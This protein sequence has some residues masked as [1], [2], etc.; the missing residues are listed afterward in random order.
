MPSN[1]SRQALRR[2]RIAGIAL[3]A[4]ILLAIAHATF[5]ALPA[6]PAGAAAWIAGGLLLGRLPGSQKLQLAVLTGVGAAT[7]AWALA[8]GADPRLL[9]LVD[10]NAMLLTMIASV[11]FL[12]LVAA[13]ERA[14]TPAPI[15][16][17]AFARTLA[18]VA[19]FGSFINVSAPL[20]IADHLHARGSLGPF[21]AQ[22]ITRVFS[23]CSAWSPFFG[24]M[25]VVLTYVP[26]ASLPWLMLAGLP[27]MAGAMAF[28]LITARLRQS[29]QVARFEGFPMTFSSLWM[30]AVL[31]LAV[32]GGHALWPGFSILALIAVSSI[33][34][35]S[36]VLVV[37][38]GARAAMR[39][40]GAHVTYGLPGMVGEL[41]LFLAAGV[42]ATGL[43]AAIS[44]SDIGPPFTHFD[45]G[46]ASWLLA[47][48]LAAAMI[49]IHPVIAVAV[50]TPWVASTAPAPQLLAMTF[51]F[52]WS[53]GT[54]AS[55]L[56]GTHLVFQGRYGIPSLQAAIRNWP[57]A[58][59]M[60]AIGTVLLHLIE[61]L[62]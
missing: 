13:P 34:L 19:A 36:T 60:Y 54:S 10:A 14:E 29:E 53:L 8:N 37:R 5:P 42:L 46:V 35:T 21:A 33:A 25:A 56:A 39:Q 47:G 32:L 24:G 31:A 41:L 18:G 12:R 58:L 3:A 59:A 61:W 45:A 23:A 11:G 4:M 9:A 43:A 51:L 28:V 7:L 15:G 40:I 2:V 6:W 50:I 49:G 20:M 55:P 48:I 44:V 38:A 1:P 16:A 62:A 30:P 52:G 26:A 22:S 17:R 27:F 57:Y